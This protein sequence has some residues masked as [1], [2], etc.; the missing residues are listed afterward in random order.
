MNPIP[1][2]SG[3]VIESNQFF[4]THPTK[5]MFD[6]SRPPHGPHVNGMMGFVNNIEKITQQM[7]QMSVQTSKPIVGQDM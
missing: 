7:G 5:T 6:P 2:W 4:W 1:Q 3:E